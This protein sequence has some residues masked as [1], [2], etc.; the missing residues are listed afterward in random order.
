MKMKMKIK[1][2]NAFALISS[3]CLAELFSYYVTNFCFISG[4]ILVYLLAFFYGFITIIYCSKNMFAE[5]VMIIE[6]DL[7]TALKNWITSNYRIF[8][9]EYKNYKNINYKAN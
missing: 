9:F 5:R 7:W 1:I 6:I 3:N 8:L 2:R 4:A